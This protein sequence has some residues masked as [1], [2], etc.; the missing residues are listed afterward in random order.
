ML[1]QSDSAVSL[2]A[3]M[4]NKKPAGPPDEEAA[5]P[6][7]SSLGHVGLYVR[8]LPRTSTPAC[9]GSK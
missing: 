7:L 4:L 3:A 1:F 2:I 6:K 9:L 8:D 5:M